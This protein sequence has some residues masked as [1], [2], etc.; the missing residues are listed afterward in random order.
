MQ[1]S[2]DF[3]LAQIVTNVAKNVKGVVFDE[4]I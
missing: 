4:A 1:T 3:A 2:L